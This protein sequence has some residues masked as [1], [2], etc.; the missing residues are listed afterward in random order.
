[1]ADLVV[2][3]T[4][5]AGHVATVPVAMRC[6]KK[7]RR[8]QGTVLR[9]GL[10]L[11]CSKE[12]AWAHLCVDHIRRAHASDMLSVAMYDATSAAEKPNARK[13]ASIC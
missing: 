5:D 8:S 2:R 6:A 7:G 3:S 11:R 9:E 4:R 1:M 13:S 10:H 12:P